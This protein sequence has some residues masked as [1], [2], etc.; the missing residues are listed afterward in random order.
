M[1]S[2]DMPAGSLSAA[3]EREHREIDEGIAE[4]STAL[5]A[6]KVQPEPLR[7][8]IRALRRHIFL[9]E[10]FI[11]PPLREAG[12]FA[13]VLV[14]VREHAAIWKTLDQ[15]DAGLQG[16]GPAADCVHR[17]RIQLLHHNMKEE[18]IVYPEADRV[19]A[20]Q[21]AGILGYGEMPQGWVCERAAG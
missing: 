12:L 8:A 17:L 20:E 13:P 9:E 18:R 15:L 11:F 5:D 4:F 14:M 19:L 16:G 2:A 6:G 10:A 3:L 7:R 21:A 1:T